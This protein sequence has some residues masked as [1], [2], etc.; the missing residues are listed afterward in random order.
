M[1]LKVL[2]TGGAGYIGATA[3]RLLVKHGHEVT[4]LDN[5]SQ[6]HREAVPA[7]ARLVIA[8]LSDRET[9]STL[10]QE[11]H[12]DAVMHFAA[13]AVVGES[14][15]FPE[16]YFRNN[17]TNSLNLLECCAANKVSRFVLS[18]TA[19]I[20][21]DPQTPLIEESSPKAPLNPY[22]ESKLQVEAMLRWF[23]QIHGVRFATLRYFNVA[24]AWD[25]HGEH[26]DPESHLIPIVLQV[27]MGKRPSVS[28]FGTNYPTPDGT[29]V[30]DYVHIYDLAM[31]HLLVMDALK[32]RE[33]LAYNLGNGNGFSVRQVIEAARKITGHPIPVIESPRRPGDPPTLVA[34][35][36]RIGK[37]LGWK[38]KYATLESIMQTAWDWHREH[39]NGYHI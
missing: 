19:A 36:E 28:V 14:M 18:S 1:G 39:P 2:I 34:S 5:L 23:Q 33:G 29:C 13:F 32:E 8:D 35:S 11:S 7:Q 3:V 25:G 9:L 24:G 12:F 17:V 37:E 10:F 30:R 38:P 26:H 22:G 16:R 20:F 15:K 6:G 21:G 4:A 31:A 27:A